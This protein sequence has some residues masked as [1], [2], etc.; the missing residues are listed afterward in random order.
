[1]GGKSLTRLNTDE[2]LIT[3]KYRE[4]KMKITLIRE[5]RGKRLEGVKGCW[6][7]VQGYW[8]VV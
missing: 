8:A 6:A 2:R 3:N 4:G 1:M 5:L 7:D